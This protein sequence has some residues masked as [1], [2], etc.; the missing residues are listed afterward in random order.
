MRTLAQKDNQRVSSSHARPK[1]ATSPP[2]HQPNHIFRLQQT[3]GNQAVLRLLQTQ[4]EVLDVGST[5]TASSRFDHD[6]PG[7]AIQHPGAERAAQT[8]S[9]SNKPEDEYSEQQF[10]HRGEYFGRGGETLGSLRAPME[11]A[12]RADFSRVRI[13]RD[14]RAAQGRPQGHRQL[15]ER[16]Q[17]S[18]ERSSRCPEAPRRPQE[19][20]PNHHEGHL[21]LNL[22]D[23]RL[24]VET[25]AKPSNNH[26]PPGV[27]KW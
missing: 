27:A 22:S 4:T 7:I 3:I 24:C 25:P 20:R 18:A 1:A 15:R 21:D 14:S 23:A 26:T 17:G 12:F 5:K 16:R 6:I 8:K 13:H 2:S 9:G 19:S 10:G 11:S